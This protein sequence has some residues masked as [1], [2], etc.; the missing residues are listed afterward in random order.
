VVR[1]VELGASQSTIRPTAGRPH[2]PRT[3][4]DS[5]RGPMQ[6]AKIATAKLS[7]PG[8]ADSVCS[9]TSVAGMTPE[10]TC[11]GCR[12]WACDSERISTTSGHRYSGNAGIIHGKT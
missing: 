12:S 1:S 9:P 2:G 11:V 10:R 8:H 3:R 5:Q 4:H 6:I 7:R